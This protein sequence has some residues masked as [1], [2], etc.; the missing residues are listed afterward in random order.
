M[1]AYGGQGPQGV[2]G[3]SPQDTQPESSQTHVAHLKTDLQFFDCVEKLCKQYNKSE[4]ASELL[5]ATV[6]AAKQTRIE[7]TRS[8]SIKDQHAALS[9][10]VTRLASKV[11]SQQQKVLNANTSFQAALAKLTADTQEL[12]KARKDLEEIED[13]LSDDGQTSISDM[14][15]IPMWQ[16]HV[17]EPVRESIY[18]LIEHASINNPTQES[19]FKLWNAM[20]TIQAYNITQT[21]S[22]PYSGEPVPVPTVQATGLDSDAIPVSTQRSKVAMLRQN[23]ETKAQQAAEAV[24]AAE[25]A[26]QAVR[27]AALEE[28]NPTFA[29]PTDTLLTPPVSPKPATPAMVDSALPTVDLTS[30]APS[31]AA[32]PPSPVTA[33]DELDTRRRRLNKKQQSQA[34]KQKENAEFEKALAENKAELEAAIE[35]ANNAIPAR[36][37]SPKRPTASGTRSNR[38]GKGRKGGKK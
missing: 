35:R 25:Q 36:E 12:E 23:C 26:E 27:D 5:A 4:R 3:A 33:T 37:R 21:P 8:G 9:G 6:A 24:A 29:R 7:I 15:F 28:P 17:P 20:E 22:D 38:A 1:G 18:H 10:L 31:A 14:S 11:E 32:G 16:Q 2:G 13:Q 30:S 34:F 19:N